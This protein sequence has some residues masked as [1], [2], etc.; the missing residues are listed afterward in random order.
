MKNLF[1]DVT[2]KRKIMKFKGRESNGYRFK[3]ENNCSL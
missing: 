3:K 2:Q 1:T